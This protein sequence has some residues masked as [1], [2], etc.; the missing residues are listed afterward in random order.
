[1]NDVK[2]DLKIL[3]LEDNPFDM[4]L[5]KELIQHEIKA[6]EF[7]CA[8]S[9]K[10]YLEG[11]ELFEPDIVLSDNCFPKFTAAEAL[12][13]LRKQSADIPFILVTGS[14]SEQHAVKIIEQGAT[15][16]ILKD[17]MA[18]LPIA[19]EAA[20]KQQRAER[21]IVDYRHA[22]NE[23]AIV[24]VTDR[25]GFI[26]EVNQ[27]YCTLSG[28]AADELAGENQ[29]NRHAAFYQDEC[30]LTIKS[31]AT[32]RG[33]IKSVAK[34]GNSYWLET[35][36]IPFED[37][38]NETFKYMIIGNDITE[39]RMLQETLHQQQQGRHLKMDTL[40]LD[41]EEKERNIIGR[42]L[43]DN[44]NQ[45]LTAI[46]LSVSAIM[47]NPLSAPERLEL[48]SKHIDKAIE[49]NRKIAHILIS[50]DI[51][52]TTLEE[53]FK[54]LVESMLTISGIQAAVDTRFLNES[55]L[56]KPQKLALYRVAQEQCSNIVKHAAAKNVV[57]VLQTGAD[58]FK[59]SIK[60][61]GR[62]VCINKNITGTGL[63]NIAGRIE[64]FNGIVRT[65]SSPGC[66]FI[67]EIE[68]PVNSQLSAT[69]PKE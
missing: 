21:E 27:N 1:M 23:A 18:R 66:G 15:D 64:I 26:T 63:K 28:Y 29:H 35:A 47:V 60:D 11:L 44:V 55:L 8:S 67:L 43:H 19:I 16:Y 22:L 38:N 51:E 3:I 39:K 24:A 9:K 10:S 36:V 52:N 62:G 57:I 20:L 42:E 25:Q 65:I 53:Q 34:N 13:I 6:T 45:L 49:E 30:L 54:T 5:M 50:P 2:P 17:R 37:T 32:W 4:I 69:T 58:N 7:Y 41:A 46:K 14:V 56:D 33:E 61:D 12:G 48:C 59:M 40:V 68:I 31:G